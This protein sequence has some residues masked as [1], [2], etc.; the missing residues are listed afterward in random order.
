MERWLS[1]RKRTIRNRLIGNYSWVRIPPSPDYFEI[2]A[3]EVLAAESLE[4]SYF[5]CQVTNA[6]ANS[7]ISAIVRNP[8]KYVEQKKTLL[9]PWINKMFS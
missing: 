2:S 4:G 5:I 7:K 9:E 6:L 3:N 8:M 1:G